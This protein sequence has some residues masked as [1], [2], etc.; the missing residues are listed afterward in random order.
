M[1]LVESQLL[2]TEEWSWKRRVSC[3]TLRNGVGR[4]E[5]VVIH[6]EMELEERSQLLFS[7][8]MELEYRS[9]LLYIHTLIGGMD[10][11]DFSNCKL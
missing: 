1:E 8:G 6:R 3:Y 11:G 10:F 2:H 9:H 7:G 5:S 4:E